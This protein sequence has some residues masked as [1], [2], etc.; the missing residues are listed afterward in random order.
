MLKKD[1]LLFT[2][3]EYIQNLGLDYKNASLF[4]LLGGHDF[5][6]RKEANEHVPKLSIVG[7]KYTL[8]HLYQSSGIKVYIDTV[9]VDESIDIIIDRLKLGNRQVIRMNCF[10][11]PYDTT[12]YRKTNSDHF[13]T[14]NHYLSETQ[15]FL[16]TDNKYHDAVISLSDFKT[17][18]IKTH[19]GEVFDLYNVDITEV[20]PQEKILTNIRDIIVE[21]CRMILE[22]A[23][24]HFQYLLDELTKIKEIDPLIMKVSLFNLAVNIKLPAGPIISRQYLMESID[25]ISDELS[26]KFTKL[27]SSWERFAVDLMKVSSTETTVD[28][29]FEE[30]VRKL[31]KL[32]LELN[33]DILHHYILSI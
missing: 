17:A 18:L 27:I 16:V 32:E 30:Y 33:E 13:I 9:R 4:H 20:Y 26:G 5:M 25:H 29:N 22:T 31:E 12:N 28:Y 1:C 21:N 19:R 24:A 8:D 15:D 23:S 10:Y 7:K 6:V 3:S 2:I 14:V 11:L